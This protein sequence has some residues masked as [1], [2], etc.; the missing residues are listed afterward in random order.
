MDI[1]KKARLLSTYPLHTNIPSHIRCGHFEF[2]DTTGEVTKYYRAGA[3]TVAMRK[4]LVPQYDTL[5]YLLGD[6]L[7]ST[8]LTT[9]TSGNL[10]VET[11]YKPWGEVR[12]TTQHSTLPTRYT[13]TGQYSYVDDE[14]TD[15]G[16]A[17]FGLM[18]YCEA[19]L[20]D[21]ARWYDP[22]LG[23]FAQAD[24]IIPGGVQG[25]DR[26]AY[27]NN[28]PVMYT[29]PSGHKCVPLEE[30][31]GYKPGS[32][33]GNG[34]ISL[35]PRAKQ[36]IDFSKSVGMTPEDVIGIGLGHEMFYDSEDEQKIHMQAFRNGFIQYADANCNGN[37]TYNCM[38]NY[39][40]G[41][42]SVK[43]QF[44]AYWGKPEK[45]KFD[46]VEGNLSDNMQ[47]YVTTGKGF[48][49]DF[50]STI[51]QYSYDPA[52]NPAD[53]DLAVNTGIV[54]VSEFLALNM[55][56]PTAAMGFLIVKPATC[57]NGDG[58]TLVY[59]WYGQDFLGDHGI[60]ACQ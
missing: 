47:K 52:H 42:Q 56:P 36:L 53:L 24:S 57:P 11:R 43:G 26:Y 7:G 4:V 1:C 21:N 20:W 29:D 49:K 54:Y 58:Y 25:L 13:Y 10:L 15:L 40:S 14:A 8:S 2:N 12:Y 45:Y 50:M 6:H 23:R 39:F 41:Y 34:G 3:Q 59:N 9:D 18:F 27:V 5:T 48:M 22:A 38:L 35:S 37:R 33:S 30:C 16:G 28:S 31:E 51:S 17:G 46:Q 60:T 55:G 44:D 32:Y 19:S